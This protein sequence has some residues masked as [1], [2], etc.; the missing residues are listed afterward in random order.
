MFGEYAAVGCVLLINATDINTTVLRPRGA[1]DEFHS[2]LMGLPCDSPQPEVEEKEGVGLGGSGGSQSGYKSWRI[3]GQ[4]PTRPYVRW[5][6][7]LGEALTHGRRSILPPP[8]L[9]PGTQPGEI[10][11]VERERRRMRGGGG[12]EG[13]RNLSA[14]LAHTKGFIAGGLPIHIWWRQVMRQL[15]S[16][17]KPSHYRSART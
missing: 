11:E 7:P 6:L 16:S 13:E 4:R 5:Q 12:G 3:A 15:S 10:N 1:F 14:L 2:C 8:R 17:E 9:P